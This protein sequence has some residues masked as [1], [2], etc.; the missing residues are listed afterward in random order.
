[1]LS[2]FCSYGQN[3]D[4]MEEK[5]KE[6]IQLS[7]RPYLKPKDNFEEQTIKVL[8]N[9]FKTKNETPAE[10][11]YWASSDFKK[12]N[13]PFRDIFDI[14]VNDT[15]KNFFQ[16]Q[17]IEII[18]TNNEGERLLK[19]SFIG[20]V[21][22]QPFIRG[23]FNI[24]AIQENDKDIKLKRPL[25]YFT[26][27]WEQQTIGNVKYVF[28]PYKKL[29]MQEV[30]RQK[31]VESKLGEYFDLEPINVTYYSSTNPEELFR[32]KGFDYNPMMYI[33]KDGGFAEGDI[34]FSGNNSEY[35]AHELVHIY[36]Q[37][38][39]PK[40]P[41]L[42]DE[43]FAMLLGGSGIHEYEWHRKKLKNYLIENPDFDL[44]VYVE[45]YEYKYIDNETSV[46][47]MVGALICEH[48][49]RK[50]GKEKLFEFFENNTDLWNNLKS[51]G[52]DKENIDL[53]L[54]NELKNYVQQRI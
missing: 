23:I 7:L 18:E 46:P 17:L 42:L 37:K 9:F 8:E 33:S 50:H 34:L 54:K 21:N 45:P 29:D 27:N 10:N 47:Y 24:L 38:K 6:D 30:E 22:N 3:N 12:Y 15:I 14:E 52:I 48:I 25:D 26:R 41:I 44:A 53:K 5:M 32:I 11:E 31:S 49:L 1:M 43:G 35:Y 28:P 13:Y 4:E 16:P 39:F 40:I 2:F 20:H 19:I 51:I 36:A